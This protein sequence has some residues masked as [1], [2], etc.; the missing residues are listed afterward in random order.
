MPVPVSYTEEEL[1]A[2]QH[3][4]LGK[5]ATVL[6]W[7]VSGGDYDEAVIDALVLYG[8]STIA[9]ATDIDKLRAC[10]RLAVWRAVAADTAGYNDVAEDQQSFKL[11]QVHDHA[12]SMV[13]RERVNAI[14]YGI[15]YEVTVERIRHINPYVVVDDS[16]RTI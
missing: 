4:V 13:K 2:Y 15:E 14:K 11:S 3:A 10:A 5:T 16:V 9:A 1:V 8:V 6:D 7:T 12:A